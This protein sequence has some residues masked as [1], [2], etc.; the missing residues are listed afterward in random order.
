M[1][2][3]KRYYSYPDDLERFPDAWC[4]LVWSKRGPGKTYSTL[5]YM[6]ENDI[7][8]L[9]LK[10]TSEDV[11]L[12][13]KGISEGKADTDLDLSP[14]KPLNRDF[15]WSIYPKQIFKGFAVFYHM[16]IDS[17]GMHPVKIAGFCMSLAKTA[18][19]KGFD[20]SEAD[21]L[22]FDEF[23]QKPW[24]RV[25]SKREG[26]A[27][28]DLYM[29]LLRDRVE[30]GRPELKLVCLANATNISNSMFT[31]LDVVNVA[32]DMD[33]TNTEFW[34]N[35]YRGILMHFINWT[36][37]V[38]K[39]PEDKLGIERAMEG[40]QWAEMAFGGHFAYN[41]FSSIGKVKLKNYQCLYGFIY[42]KHEYYVFKRDLDYYVSRVRGTAKTMYDLSREVVQKKFFLSKGKD[43]RIAA[44]NEHVVFGD[45]V[46]YDLIM[47]YKKLYS[48]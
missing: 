33:A 44:I 18:S 19:F 12:L 10:R 36:D 21:F 37:E 15:G 14:F 26:D 24:E 40:T 3:S 16:Q 17:D 23:I 34:Y 30:R 28:M 31:I 7:K 25:I 29:T 22:I 43:L 4:Y 32:A 11:E 2:K 5:R 39:N 47:N 8:F 9:F 42:N 35:K 41:D 13:C 1:R 6:V 38:Q 27:V 45:Y 20:I 48:L 46:S